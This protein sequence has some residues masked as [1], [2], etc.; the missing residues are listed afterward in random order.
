MVFNQIVVWWPLPFPFESYSL[1]GT[2][3]MKTKIGK[4]KATRTAVQWRLC[5]EM[6]FLPWQSQVKLTSHHLQLCRSEIFFL[7]KC[8]KIKNR[9][10]LKFSGRE[11]GRA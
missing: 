2:K 9:N 4:F 1:T 5:G 6:Y 11:G 10:N 7:P 3:G 8:L